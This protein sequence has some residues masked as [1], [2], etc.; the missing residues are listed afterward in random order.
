MQLNQL[1]KIYFIG[2]G[3]IGMSAIARY[4]NAK[5]VE[6]HGYDRTKTTLCQKLEEE[7]IKIHYTDDVSSIPD[8]VNLVIYTPAIKNLAELTHFKEKNVPI[9]KRAEVLGLI[10]R[11]MKCIA[12]AG[13]HGKTTTSSIVT[14]LLIMGGVDVTAFLGGI[15]MSIG[16]NFVQGKSEW[17]V[18][19]A[20]EY[21]R[22][23]LQLSP[24]I[25]IILSVDPDHLDIYGNKKTFREAFGLFQRKIKPQGICFIKKG[26][27]VLMPKDAFTK[28][29]SDK[30]QNTSAFTQNTFGVNKGQYKATKLRVENGQFVFDYKSPTHEILNIHTTL[31]GQHN[32]ENATAAIAVALEVGVS[33]EN[34]KI[35][36][37]TFKGI[38]RRFEIIYQNT[39][40]QITYIDDYAHHPTELNAAI[41]A[42][43]MLYPKRR[44]I[45]VFQPHLFSRTRDFQQG[46]ADALDKLDD[47]LLMDIYPARELP[48]EGVTAEILLENMKNPR[49]NI[50][51]KA[52]MMNILRGL[53]ENSD[54]KNITILTLGAGDI[55][56]FVPQIKMWLEQR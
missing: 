34:I 48:I 55:D 12:V 51:P 10:S 37:A 43:R 35:A 1:K 17:V 53:L 31:P 56:T 28:K 14:H 6:I 29:A 20:D 19:E 18:V 42:A 15:S 24:N 2:I 33:P 52:E 39:E 7:G 13:T 36:L 45:G 47:V 11:E 4:F 27:K 41:A 21:D 32:V 9:M 8:D 46:F 22:S 25:A 5:G 50:A 44:L 23:F 38:K 40:K 49:K 54:E 30:I 16:S 3:G 26:V